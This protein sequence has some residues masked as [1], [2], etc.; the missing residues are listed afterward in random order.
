MGEGAEPL[1]VDEKEVKVYM[2]ELYSA[3]R[4]IMEPTCLFSKGYYYHFPSP[5]DNCFA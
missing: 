4:S 5:R 2:S 1:G 3:K